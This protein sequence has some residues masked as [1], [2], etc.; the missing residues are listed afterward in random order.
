MKKTVLFTALGLAAVA[1]QAQQ[2]PYQPPYQTQAQVQSAPVPQYQQPQY[3]DAPASETARVISSTPV[4]QQ[5]AVPRQVC[6]QQPVVVEGPRTSGAGSIIGAI[7]GGLLGNTIGH[8]GGRAAATAIGVLGGAMVG[9]SVEANGNPGYVQNA[10]HCTTQTTYE[11][12]TVAY[13]VTYE[14]NGRQYTTQMPQDPGPTIRLQ[15][16]PMGAN[17]APPVDHYASPAPVYSD[18]PQ[19]V[20]INRPVVVPSTAVYPIGYYGP[21][22]PPVGISLNL[23]YSRGWHGG[24]HHHHH[25]HW[26]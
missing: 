16:S 19:A 13:N 12:R 17:S 25:R 5:V 21:Y 3:Q 4:V 1:A 2:Y 7:A 18:V 8:G 22:Y 20:I 14:Y 11:N 6:S 15:L 10:Q 9:N 23:G 24:H 26:R